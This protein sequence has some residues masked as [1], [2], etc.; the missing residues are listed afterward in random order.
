MLISKQEGKISVSTGQCLETIPK[1]SS[2][3]IGHLVATHKLVS[4]SHWGSKIVCRSTA[5]QKM[6][7]HTSN[8]SSYF[9]SGS[10]FG[11]KIKVCF[12]THAGLAH[13]ELCAIQAR[14]ATN[15]G[16]RL[17]SMQ[18]TKFP[19]SRALIVYR[20]VVCL[21]KSVTVFFLPCIEMWG[22][23]WGP[24]NVITLWCFWCRVGK[25]F[26]WSCRISGLVVS[27]EGSEL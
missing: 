25:W 2:N 7:M 17:E 16:L 4:V 21:D 19:C 27:G 15:R 20:L 10:W 24:Y 9:G 13:I 3:F 11:A 26:P 8:W 5:I 1:S 6:Y 22:K 18:M 14:R 23:V 12:T